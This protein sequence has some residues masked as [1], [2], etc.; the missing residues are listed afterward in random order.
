METAEM[1]IDT[2]TVR[3]LGFLDRCDRCSSQAFV[4]VSLN[5]GDLLFCGHDF[6]KHEAAL[7]SQAIEIVD[8]RQYIDEKYG[9]TA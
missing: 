9:L 5:S 6:H 8:E 3:V 1:A 4:K 7:R 2:P